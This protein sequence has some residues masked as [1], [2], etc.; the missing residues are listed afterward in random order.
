M[1]SRNII[2][3][4]FGA[5]WQGVNGLRKLLHLFLLLF[6]FMLFFGV[7]SDEAPPILPEKAALVIKPVGMLVEQ[8]NGDPYERALG[9]LMGQSQPQTLVQDVV[10]ALD[11]ASTDKRIAAVH[12]ELSSLAGGGIDKLR[13]ISDAVVEFKKSGKPV[14]ASADFFMQQGYYIAAHADEIYMNPEGAIFL[15]GYGTYRTYY[16]DAIELLRIDWNVFR[17]GTHKSFVEPYTRMDMS[18]EDR[19]SRQRL[20]DYMWDSYQADVVEA[21]GMTA[22]GIHDYAENLIAHTKIAGGDLGVAARDRGLVDKLLGRTELKDVMIAH[23]GESDSDDT[24]YSAVGMNEYLS[25]LSL[26]RDKKANSQNVAVVIASGSILDGSQPPGTIGGEST[27]ALLRKAR[28]DDSVKAVVLRVDSGGGSAFA[29]EVIAEEVRALRAADKPVVA[30]MGSVAASGGYWISM[31]ADRIY[32]SPTTITGS[33]G[34]LGMFPTFQRTLA[35]IGI[36]TDGVGTTP[37]SGQLRPDREMNDDAKQ[38]IQTLINDGYQDFIQG[39]ASGRELDVDYVDKIGQGQVWSGEEALANGLVDELGGLEDAIAG[40]AEL[41]EMDDYGEILIEKELSSTQQ[42]ILDLLSIAKTLGVDPAA[43]A[44]APSPIELFANH[45]H[46]LLASVAQFN[47]PLGM[48]S[49][50]FCEIR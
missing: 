24:T 21:R 16:K 42:M 8:L 25:Q 15:Q 49:H 39:V 44:T 4:F 31:D 2:F 50:C 47:D 12:L 46:E 3:R 11:H 22:N 32:A 5:I 26:R 10:D 9:E 14:I 18:P 40:A 37:W 38:L 19:E 17:V 20:V 30:S 7:L 29:S 27:A 6:I 34:I 35:T 1:S 41:A 48:Y 36:A 43:L 23:V 13:R 45:L 33:I 28:K